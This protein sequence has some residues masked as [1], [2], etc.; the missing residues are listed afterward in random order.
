MKLAIIQQAANPRD[1][2]ALPYACQL[3]EAA[4]RAGGQVIVLP[5]LFRWPYPAQTMDPSGFDRAEPISGETVETMRA[6]AARLQVVIVVSFFEE[7]APGLGANTAVVLG[8]EGET[9]GVYRKAH[10][11]E[12]PLYYEKFYFTPGDEPCGVFDT[13]FGRIGV[14]VCWDQWYPEAARIAAMGGAEV[15]IYPTA[16]GTIDEEGPAEHARQLDAWRIVQR[17]HAVAN[18]IFV[19]AV[20]RVGREGELGFWGHSFVAGPQGELLCDLA[21]QADAIEIIDCDRG[22]MV[23]VRRMWPFFRDRR[24]DLYGDITRRWRD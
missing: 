20:N 4:A 8:P 11:P 6:L 16:I 12:D 2:D 24:I 3:V 15:L 7:R 21:E 13:P 22:R 23:E 9:L 5:E 1:T 14:L 10:I 17:G 18:G 19:A